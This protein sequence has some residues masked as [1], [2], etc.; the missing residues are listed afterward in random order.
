MDWSTVVA[1]GRS[2]RGD[3]ALSLAEDAA[4]FGSTLLMVFLPLVFLALLALV[5]IATARF[6]RGSSAPS[7]AG[8]ARRRGRD[9]TESVG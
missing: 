5:V 8:G 3:R 6:P 1:T 7:G 2:R 9:H 4:A